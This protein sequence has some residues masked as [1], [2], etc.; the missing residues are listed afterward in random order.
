[1][2]DRTILQITIS[3]IHLFNFYLT[4]GLW[5]FD[6]FYFFKTLLILDWKQKCNRKLLKLGLINFP[7]LAASWQLLY[8][9]AVQYTG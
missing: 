8:I 1:M 5:Q 4:A 2:S 9:Y 3:T 6:L 7:V